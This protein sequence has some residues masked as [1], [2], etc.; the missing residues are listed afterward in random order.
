MASLNTQHV[1]SWRRWAIAAEDHTRSLLTAKNRKVRLQVAEAHQNWTIE[2]QKNIAWWDELH[3]SDGWSEFWCKQHDGAHASCLVSKVQA[4]AGA[5]MVCCGTGASH[6]SCAVD[7]SAATVMLSYQ[8]GPKSQ[9]WFHNL[10]ESLLQRVKAVLKAKRGPTFYLQGGPNKV[11]NECIWGCF[12][13][14]CFRNCDS[15]ALCAFTVALTGIL[16][17]LTF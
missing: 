2:E 9:E 3:H 11:A 1:E 5:V 7:R 10:V 4:A 8:Y 17:S 15:S 14:L 13:I 6:L 12:F 16:E